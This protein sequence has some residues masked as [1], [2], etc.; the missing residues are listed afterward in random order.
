MRSMPET[1]HCPG[2]DLEMPKGPNLYDG[3]YNASPECVSVYNEV[4]GTEFGHLLLFA[5]VH[6][7]TVDAYAVQHAGA[8]HK[9]KSVCVH[10]VGLHLAIDHGIQ[11]RE[12]APYLQRLAKKTDAWP[13]FE[14][15]VETGPL[16]VFDIAMAGPEQHVEQVRAWARQLWSAWTPQH[17]AVADLA[18]VAFA[19]S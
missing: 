16:T 11:S 19:G 15:P 14:P 4:L 5:K 6:Q 10:L 17:D 12:I 18:E 8:A 9:D 13:H 3:Y 1:T 2:C 7:L